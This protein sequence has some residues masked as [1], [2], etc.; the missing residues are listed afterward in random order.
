MRAGEHVMDAGPP[1]RRGRPLEEHELR[2]PSRARERRREQRSSA[3]QWAS[4]SCSSAS[5][6]PLRRERPVAHGRRG[7][8][9]SHALQHAAHERGELRLRARAP[10]RGCDP[11]V[12]GSSVSGRHRSVMIEQPS[13]R[14]PACT[15]DDHLGHRGHADDVGTERAQH[16]VL[17]ARLEVRARNG[18]VHALA[19][20]DPRSRATSR[21]SAR[22]AS[23]YGA[24]MSG[25]RGP[26]ASSFGPMSGLS[27]SRLMWSAMSIRSPGVHAG[28][29]PPH[30][31]DTTSV[32][33][34]SARSTRTGN[35]TCC[36]RIALVA[37]KSPLHRHHALPAER[38]A[39]AGAPRATR[40]STAGTRDVG[41]RDRPPASRSLGRARPVRCRG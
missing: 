19:Q 12:A 28:C 29:M 30:A 34:P 32:C 33:A 20:R 22:N 10:W 14:I 13:T 40:R 24:D 23:S 25:K 3:C 39:A 37:V 27:P 41:V 11:S 17:G 1:V 31:L 8:S 16:A 9:R 2:R 21:A 36:S 7:A 6:R 35:V 15:G 5:R 4:S 38:A 26:S 18:D